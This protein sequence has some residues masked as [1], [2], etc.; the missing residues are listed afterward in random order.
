MTS[1][2]FTVTIIKE[3]GAAEFHLST[4]TNHRTLALSEEADAI[5]HNRKYPH[6]ATLEEC[7]KAD[8]RLEQYWQARERANEAMLEFTGDPFAGKETNPDHKKEVDAWLRILRK[9]DT[10][11]NEIKRAIV[12]ISEMAKGR[13]RQ[14]AEAAAEAIEDRKV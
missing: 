11:A 8:T 4:A 13:T 7:E 5:M 2:Q 6:T 12:T 1:G 10:Q 9:K 3:A 14:E